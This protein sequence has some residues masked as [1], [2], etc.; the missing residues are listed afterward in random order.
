MADMV[1]V[2]T[3]VTERKYN[4]GNLVRAVEAIWG[5]LCA[6]DAGNV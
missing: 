2:K 6:D 5:M 4:N 1:K 3:T